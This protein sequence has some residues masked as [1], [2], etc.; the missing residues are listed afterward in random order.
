MHVK[1][2]LE[3]ETYL[4]RRERYYGINWFGFNTSFHNS[5]SKENT[6]MRKNKRNL[7]GVGGLL[8]VSF[9]RDGRLGSSDFDPSYFKPNNV[10]FRYPVLGPLPRIPRSNPPPPPPPGLISK[11]HPR[12]CKIHT[13]NLMVTIYKHWLQSI[14]HR[15][16]AKTMLILWH[17]TNTSSSSPPGG[18]TT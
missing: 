18:W 5:F 1:G 7:S 15:N 3:K 4:Y 6:F 11:I 2:F 12:F 16:D 9:G 14:S 13:R 8:V 17:R 10:I